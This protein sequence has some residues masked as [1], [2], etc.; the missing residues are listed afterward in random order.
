MFDEWVEKGEK[1]RISAGTRGGR[2]GAA[3]TYQW[4]VYD[5][6]EESWENSDDDT[7]DEATFTPKIKEKGQHQFRVKVTIDG[8]TKESDPATVKGAEKAVEKGKNPWKSSCTKILHSW[9]DEPFRSSGSSTRYIHLYKA[10]GNILSSLL[11][12]PQDFF[13]EGSGCFKARFGYYTAG[14][15][16]AAIGGNL[17]HQ[18]HRLPDG[19]ATDTQL[20]RGDLDLDIIAG[21]YRLSDDPD[22]IEMEPAYYDCTYCK[23]GYVETEPMDVSYRYLLR[24]LVKVQGSHAVSDVPDITWQSPVGLPPERCGLDTPPRF[25]NWKAF[26]K[27]ISLELGDLASHC[28]VHWK[29]AFENELKKDIPFSQAQQI[30]DRV[31]PRFIR[32]GGSP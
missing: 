3:R 7:A 13:P 27:W 18:E 10:S 12:G 17:I 2:I 16:S 6:D 1:A 26:G 25:K 32:P 31:I 19:T 30:V 29:G 8:T 28:S 14:A 9:P 4:Q 20:A 23:G 5:V 11:E 15:A 24:P 21:L 22:A